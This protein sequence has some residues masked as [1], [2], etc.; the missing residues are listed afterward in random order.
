MQI[1]DQDGANRASAGRPIS[2]RD[3]R[4]SQQRLGGGLPISEQ[5]HSSGRRANKQDDAKHRRD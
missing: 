5:Q 1:G 4:T 3:P 2:K